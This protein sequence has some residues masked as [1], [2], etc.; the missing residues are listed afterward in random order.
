MLLVVLCF[1]IIGFLVLPWKPSQ[2]YRKMQFAFE[3]NK[4][5]LEINFHLNFPFSF[6]IVTVD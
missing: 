1:M 6:V 2:F 3:V 5:E 4:R